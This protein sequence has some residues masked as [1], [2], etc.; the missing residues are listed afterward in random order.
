MNIYAIAA[1]NV[2]NIIGV[3]GAIPWNNKED[4]AF[5]KETTSGH[6]VI[7]GRKTFESLNRPKGLPNR[8]NVVVSRTLENDLSNENVTVVDSLA[9]AYKAVLMTDHDTCFIMGGGEIYKEALESGMVERLYLTIVDA[10][11]QR[12]LPEKYV[13]H[14]PKLKRGNWTFDDVRCGERIGMLSPNIYMEL[15]HISK[16]C[17]CYS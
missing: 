16:I 6:A 3:N 8:F 4:M 13:T 7:M 17:Q 12:D 9:E 1:M 11:V 14:F 2:N 15:N 10:I 5:F